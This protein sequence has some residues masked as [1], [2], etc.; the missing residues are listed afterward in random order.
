MRS[1]YEVDVQVVLGVTQ[2]RTCLPLA[3]MHVLTCLPVDF[4]CIEKVRVTAAAPMSPTKA[5]CSTGRG[6]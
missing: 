2:Q 1:S 3:E 5:E 4:E 6:Q